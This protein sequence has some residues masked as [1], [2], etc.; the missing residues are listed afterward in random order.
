MNEDKMAWHQAGTP[1]VHERP[2]RRRKKERYGGAKSF[3][4]EMVEHLKDD[5][6]RAAIHGGLALGQQVAK[7]AARSQVTGALGVGLRVGG[8]IGL[9]VIPV[10]GVALVAYDLYQFGKWLAE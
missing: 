9:R 3:R 2:N 4:G 1:G 5:A 7:Y 8:R 10:V 6:R